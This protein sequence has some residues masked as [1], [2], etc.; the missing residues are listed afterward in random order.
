M[1]IVDHLSMSMWQLT[2]IFRLASANLKPVLRYEENPLNGPK[3]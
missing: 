1:C 2:K 3:G